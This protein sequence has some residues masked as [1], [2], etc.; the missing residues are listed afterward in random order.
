MQ[1]CKPVES[2]PANNRKIDCCE[3]NGGTLTHTL[4]K[5]EPVD[6]TKPRDFTWGFLV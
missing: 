4:G 3:F 2:L 5:R 1:N 6:H